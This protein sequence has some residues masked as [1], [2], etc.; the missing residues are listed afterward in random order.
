VEPHR[1]QRT[2]HGGFPARLRIHAALESARSGMTPP[3][4]QLASGGH[5]TVSRSRTPG[6]HKLVLRPMHVDQVTSGRVG[7]RAKAR[8][9][10][11]S[12]DEPGRLPP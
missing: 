1:D 3:E 12:Y 4:R 11:P 8:G 7:L 5:P 9:A 2:R 6:V 10:Q